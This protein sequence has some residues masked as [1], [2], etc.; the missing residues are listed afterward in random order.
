MWRMF[1]KHGDLVWGLTRSCRSTIL[2]TISDTMLT[3][4]PYMFVRR[5]LQSES[6][7]VK[8]VANYCV[9]MVVCYLDLDCN[10]QT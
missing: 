5:C 8:T 2:C 6:V 4:D 10:V 1:A 3:L 7:L 9:F